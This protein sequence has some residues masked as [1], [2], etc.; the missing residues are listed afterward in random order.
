MM[1]ILTPATERLINEALKNGHYKD[2]DAVIQR[3]LH[4][5]HAAHQASPSRVNEC[6]EA[7]V[8]IRELRQGNTLG[9]LTIKELINEGRR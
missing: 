6:Q 9:G 2:A 3:A 4:V 1:I 7:A 5:L 8:R